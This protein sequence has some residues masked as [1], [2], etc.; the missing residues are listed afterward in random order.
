MVTGSQPAYLLQPALLLTEPI[1]SV[2]GSAGNFIE[3]D[4]MSW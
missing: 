4:V 2:D 1:K 3:H